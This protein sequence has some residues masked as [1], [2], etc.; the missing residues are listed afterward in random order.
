MPQLELLNH[1]YF[2]WRGSNNVV[3]SVPVVTATITTRITSSSIQTVL[4]ADPV[5][6]VQCRTSGMEQSNI[7]AGR[8]MFAQTK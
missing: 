3:Y 5:A 8:K 7:C 2:Y 4:V 1:S 6:V